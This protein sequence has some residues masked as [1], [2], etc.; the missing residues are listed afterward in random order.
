MKQ[1]LSILLVQFVAMAPAPVALAAAA[2]AKPIE[3]TFNPSPPRE[4]IPPNH[5]TPVPSGMN[6]RSQATKNP[7]IRNSWWTDTCT[8]HEPTLM[9]KKANPKASSHGPTLS[10]FI[11][12]LSTNDNV[13]SDAKS[14]LQAAYRNAMVD[15][16]QTANK[17]PDSIES[18]PP[19]TDP[20]VVNAYNQFSA[21]CDQF[22]NVSKTDGA[23][24]QLKG[25]CDSGE[26]NA[27]SQSVQDQGD[28]SRRFIYFRHDFIIQANK[29]LQNTSDPAVT[30]ALNDAI[31]RAR[32]DIKAC[33]QTAWSSSKKMYLCKVAGGTT[34]KDGT[35]N[36]PTDGTSATSAGKCDKYV[37]SV[38]KNYDTIVEALN[39]G[40]GV[41]TSEPA[42]ATAPT[43]GVDEA[44]LV[45]H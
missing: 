41:P 10:N 1:M 14:V 37:A 40:T 7:N 36:Q 24:A 15:A 32:A 9:E 2:P 29:A 11:Q 43:T 38:G 30:K 18:E 17:P 25:S 19:N 42:V 39:I 3:P 35:C 13:S 31:G 34:Q 26:T 20:D 44:S 23:L 6:T 4:V 21:A 5:E 27:L 33:P 45:A 16:Q 28:D 8:Y 12:S 22:A